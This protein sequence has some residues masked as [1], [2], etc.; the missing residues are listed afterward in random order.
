MKSLRKA[1]AVSYVIIV[2]LIGCIIYF[3]L[4][5]WRQID[6]LEQESRQ[7]HLVR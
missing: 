2:A 7:I 5:E 1:I 4:Y 3:Y 6:R